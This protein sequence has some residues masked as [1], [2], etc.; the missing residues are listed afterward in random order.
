M[1]YDPANDILGLAGEVAW[2]SENINL[3]VSLGEVNDLEPGLVFKDGT[4]ASLDAQLSGSGLSVAGLTLAPDNARLLY[5]RAPTVQEEPTFGISGGFR[6]E[7]EGF[8]FTLS[9]GGDSSN[10]P[11]LLFNEGSVA[12]LNASLSSSFI[13]GGTEL[14]FQN[15]EIA[16]SRVED[17]LAF[18]GQASTL[19][20]RV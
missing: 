6:I 5:R 16:Y 4:I 19:Y 13:L 20:Q 12:S 8:N 7:T 3:N 17:T 18:R 2:S 14:A 9:V 11:G 15:T 10:T 1:L